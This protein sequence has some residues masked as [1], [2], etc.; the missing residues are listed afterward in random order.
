MH[1]SDASTTLPHPPAASLLFRSDSRCVV[2]VFGGKETNFNIQ[3]SAAALAM[4][5]DF[6]NAHCYPLAS[7][8][9]TAYAEGLMLVYPPQPP[10]PPSPRPPRPPPPPPSPSPRPPKPSPPPSPTPPPSPPSP[11][12]SPSPPSPSPSPPPSKLYHRA[13][14]FWGFLLA[15][16]WESYEWFKHALL[17]MYLYLSIVSCLLNDRCLD[18]PNVDRALTALICWCQGHSKSI[19]AGVSWY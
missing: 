2:A 6:N 19:A 1:C 17:V 11:P 14:V 8:D 7:W 15:S 18:V 13:C 9:Q 3:G 5:G 4:P 12:P 10:P 16:A